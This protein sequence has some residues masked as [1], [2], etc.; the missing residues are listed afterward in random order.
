MIFVLQVWVHQRCNP[1]SPWWWNQVNWSLWCLALPHLLQELAPSHWEHWYS[2]GVRNPLPQHR[3]CHPAELH[4]VREPGWRWWSP[5]TWSTIR[6]SGSTSTPPSTW[7]VC[8]SFLAD[9]STRLHTWNKSSRKYIRARPT[10]NQCSQ[11]WFTFLIRFYRM[12][13]R[14]IL[15]NGMDREQGTSDMGSAMR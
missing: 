11:T 10:S 8:I 9:A 3:D 7:Y 13:D 1:W 12:S 14:R 2:V 4:Q 15:Q 6:S 5:G